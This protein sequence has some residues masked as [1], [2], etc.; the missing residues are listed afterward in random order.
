MRIQFLLFV[1]IFI[2]CIDGEPTL[3]IRLN[4]K[5]FKDFG[6]VLKNALQNKVKLLKLPS[7]TVSFGSGTADIKNLKM[8]SFKSPDM[9]ISP[10]APN[11]IMFSG[12]G[13]SISITGSWN[14]AYRFLWTMHFSGDLSLEISDAKPF[15]RIN[16]LSKQGKPQIYVEECQMKIGYLNLNLYGGLGAWI[17]NHFTSGVQDNIKNSLQKEVCKHVQDNVQTVNKW[18]WLPHEQ[19]LVD[20]IYFNQHLLDNPKVTENFLQLDFHAY[21]SFG[22]SKCNLQS[23]KIND[24]KTGSN[25]MLTTWLGEP[26]I[27]CYLKTRYEKNNS[28]VYI[29]NSNQFR[30]LF[31]ENCTGTKNCVRKVNNPNMNFKHP[32]DLDIYLIK[33]PFLYAAKNG[34][35]LKTSMKIVFY[36]SPRKSN[37]LKLAELTIQ[38]KSSIKFAVSDG[39]IHFFT[40]KMTATISESND[41][42]VENLK[43]TILDASTDVAKYALQNLQLLGF[44]DNIL[45]RGPS[46]LKFS[47]NAVFTEINK[48]IR[49]DMDVTISDI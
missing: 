36:Q 46:Q 12:S 35:D 49:A 27:N 16:L 25:H 21:L 33:A 40:E 1:Q 24:R 22:K 48:F 32:V 6:L 28:H 10:I 14:V 23:K 44:V 47:K 30:E 34:F 20:N 39:K 42:K 4:Q 26:V 43:K 19:I 2:S 37:S 38:T 5:G 45:Y 29:A 41:L 3:R 11:G 17:V 15:M 7:M 31:N 8:N 13:S 9:V 18:L